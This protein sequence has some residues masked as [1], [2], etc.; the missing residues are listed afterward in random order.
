MI[1]LRSS[2]TPSQVCFENTAVNILS[3]L[4]HKLFAIR[5]TFYRWLQKIEQNIGLFVNTV[6]IS[7]FKFNT[8]Q[9]SKNIRLFIVEVLNF[10]LGIT[11][12]ISVTTATSLM[13]KRTVHKNT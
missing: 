11:L 8:A 9:N 7:L 1:K 6:C 5:N 12:R 2:W 4:F 10:K 3:R 13:A